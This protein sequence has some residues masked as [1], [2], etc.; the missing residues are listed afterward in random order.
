MTID[1]EVIATWKHLEKPYIYYTEDAFAC[2][3]SFPWHTIKSVS[4]DVIPKSS[5]F[6]AEQYATLVAFPALFHKNRFALLYSNCQS[7]K[8]EDCELK[9]GVDKLFDEGGSGK[10][11]KQGV[12]IQLVSEGEE[13]VA[14][15]AAPL[16][17]RHQKKQKTAAVDADSSHHSGANIAKTEIDSFARPS[18]LVITATTTITQTAG[19]A[20]VLKEKIVKPSL[21]LLILPH[22][23]LISPRVV[24]WIFLMYLSAEVRMHTEY[25]IKEKRRLKFVVDDQTELLKVREIEIGDLRA[26]LLVKESETMKPSISMPKPPTEN[27]AASVK[28]KDQEVADLD[29][30]V[31]SVKLQNDNVTDQVHKLKTS[32]TRLQEKVTAYKNLISQLEKFQDDRMKEMNDKFDKLD[33]DLVEMALHMEEKFYPHLLTTIFATIGKA[34]K[35]GMQDGLS[36]G[37]THG[38]EGRVLNDVGAYNPSA[39]ADYLS[40]LQR[41]QSVNFS[42]I[43]ELKSNK[44]ASID[45]IMDLLRLEDSLANKFGLT[46]SARM[47][48]ENIANHRSALHNVVVPLFEPLSITDLTC[49]KGTS[50]VIPTTV[51]TTTALSVTFSSASLIPPI[52]TDDYEIVH[53]KSGESV[54]AD[55][56]PFPNVDDVELNTS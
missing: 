21:F 45:T 39:K 40:S 28:V 23:E 37:I 30:M 32:F 25:N 50:N 47:I 31:T 36:A 48:K 52:F 34:V 20:T 19:P 17:P 15:D 3:V 8:G 54:G 16:R 24:L 11:A 9:A 44:D 1:L 29:A 7:Y 26:Q 35:K 18:A 46:E 55:A 5:K 42:S 27:L 53:A 6:N 43:P 41:L 51:D 22:L 56:D 10:Q 49:T 12:G 2:P 14:E 4:R 38:V 13:I 33:T